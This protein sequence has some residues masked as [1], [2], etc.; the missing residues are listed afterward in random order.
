MSKKRQANSPIIGKEKSRKEDMSET[1][2]TSGQDDLLAMSQDSYGTAASQDSRTS[3]LIRKLIFMTKKPDGAFRD[4]IVVE[5]QTLDDKPFKG[6]ITPK[7]VRR[8]IF[9]DVLGFKQADLIGFYFAYSGCPIVTFKL[10]EQFNIDSLE[11]FKEF[12]VE[13]KCRI[14]NEEKTAILRCKVRGIRTNQNN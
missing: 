9:E 12:N 3:K 14:G 6:S 8:T 5:I 10:K 11:S 7:E 4:E 1:G 13:R 2:S